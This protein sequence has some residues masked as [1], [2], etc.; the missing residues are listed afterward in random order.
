VANLRA[1]LRSVTAMSQQLGPALEDLA[2]Q[3]QRTAELAARLQAR[4][5]DGGAA[6]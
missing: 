4:R 2:A 6:E 3:S 5:P 1:L